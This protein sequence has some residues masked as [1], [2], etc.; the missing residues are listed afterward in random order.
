MDQNPGDASVFKHIRRLVDEEHRLFNQGP[1]SDD[2]RRRLPAIQTELDRCWDLLRQRRA[3]REF[4]GDASDARVRD[5]GIVK[6][7]SG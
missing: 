7:Y 3:L 6:N 5:A 4:G 2:E 1:V